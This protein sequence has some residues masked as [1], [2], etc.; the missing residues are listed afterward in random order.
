MQTLGRF[1]PFQQVAGKTELGSTIT[2]DG[3]AELKAMSSTITH[4]GREWTV[5]RLPSALDASRSTNRVRPWLNRDQEAV[6]Q[7]ERIAR[8]RR[9]NGIPSPEEW[10]W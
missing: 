3:M 9:D 2:Q 10:M 5:T 4:G 1:E 8:A 7:I 6:R